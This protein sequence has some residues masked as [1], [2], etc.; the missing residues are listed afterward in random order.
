MPTEKT[1]TK[2]I[3]VWLKQ[4]PGVFF[5]KVHGDPFQT[6]G[7]PDLILC[8]SGRFVGLEV[9]QPGKKPTP[10]QTRTL[11]KIKEAGGASAIVT[12]LDEVKE[13]ISTNFNL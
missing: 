9:K 3:Q 5:Y 1:I 11:E 2:N 12:S 8:V 13:I 4:Q 7:L 6:A 10:L